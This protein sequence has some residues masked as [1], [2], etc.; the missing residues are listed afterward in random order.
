MTEPIS[1]ARA[2]IEYETCA[3]CGCKANIVEDVFSGDVEHIDNYAGDESRVEDV[4]VT[5]ATCT[6]CE[7]GARYV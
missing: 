3:R 6:E 7:W 2:V 1:V 4:V 5:E